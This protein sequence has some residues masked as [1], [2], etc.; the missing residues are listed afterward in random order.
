MKPV[1]QELHWLRVRQRITITYKT[2]LLVYK[3]VHGLAPPYLATFC[4]PTS[5]SSGRSRLRSANLHLRTKT[6]YGDR[7][8]AVS[9]PTICM[10]QS[11]SWVAIANFQARAEDVSFQH[12]LLIAYLWKWH[13]RICAPQ[14][15][16]SLSLFG[17]I[18]GVTDGQTDGRNCRVTRI[19]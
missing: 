19:A 3:C 2:A 4:H 9:G 6:N 5:Q 8:F 17:W 13:L 15:S 14:M 18:S 11:P 7:S 10:E 12:R 1:L 16:L